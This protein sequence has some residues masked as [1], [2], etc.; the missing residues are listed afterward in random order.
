MQTES[1]RV[2]PELV[3]RVARTSTSPDD[4]T[5]RVCPPMPDKNPALREIQR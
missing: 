1:N 5:S 3:E 2:S 4:P